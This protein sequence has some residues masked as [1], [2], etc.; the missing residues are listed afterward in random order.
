[1]TANVMLAGKCDVSR[2]MSGHANIS[3]SQD[4]GTLKITCYLNFSR[5]RLNVASNLNIFGSQD[6]LAL[7][8]TL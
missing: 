3:R 7:E 6:G 1:M 5:L 4:G 2:Q 8:E